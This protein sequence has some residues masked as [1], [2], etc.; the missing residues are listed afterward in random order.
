MLQ[1]LENVGSRLDNGPT[2][3]LT[4]M[5]ACME[6]GLV[7]LVRLSYWDCRLAPLSPS[8]SL[9]AYLISELPCFKIVVRHGAWL[10]EPCE[11]STF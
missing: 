2:G 1:K 5:A 3:Q 9:V 6:A 10:D 8:P 7:T 11:T 4:R